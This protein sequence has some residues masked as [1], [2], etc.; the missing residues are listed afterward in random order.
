[1]ADSLKKSGVDLE[2][3]EN[4]LKLEEKLKT[5]GELL[6]ILNKIIELQC[7]CLFSALHLK[8]LLQLMTPNDKNF[9]SKLFRN[10][11]KIKAKIDY[12]P[13]IKNL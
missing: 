1:M 6:L 7:Q 5:K 2:V 9:I 11:T 4:S 13:K 12:I 3:E 10:F 8:I